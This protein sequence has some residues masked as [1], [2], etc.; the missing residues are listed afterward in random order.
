MISFLFVFMVATGR[1][2]QSSFQVL[3]EGRNKDISFLKAQAEYNVSKDITYC[4]G[5]FVPS[6]VDKWK[7]EKKD[8]KTRCSRK[9]KCK[10]VLKNFSRKTLS[11][12]AKR[13]LKKVDK[14][15]SDYDIRFF[16]L[17]K[18]NKT[19]IN[20][21]KKKMIVG[22]GPL[23]AASSSTDKMKETVL[24]Q[25]EE[26]PIWPETLELVPENEQV[27]SVKGKETKVEGLAAETPVVEVD[28]V[29]TDWVAKGK[30]SPDGVPV[31]RDVVSRDEDREDKR[32]PV[33][34]SRFKSFAL[35]AMKV[36]NDTG[37]FTTFNG[38]WGP[39]FQF[40]SHYILR[41]E[42]GMHFNRVASE[43]RDITFMVISLQMHLTYLF[44]S[45]LFLEAGG[46]R[47][48]WRNDERNDFY[49]FTVGA[50]YRF[51]THILRAVDRIFV[52]MGLV[53]SDDNI[54][55]MKAGVGLSF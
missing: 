26:P 32:I 2:E 19:K 49:M 3:F 33:S 44:E 53:G 37:D 27:Q 42:A 46:G 15:K 24:E 41:G 48:F 47:Q 52:S 40:N 51:R 12:I 13:K 10:R 9:Y 8:K 16:S 7:C 5:Y 18:K 4:R 28:N 43:I 20:Q 35:T 39:Y 36:S 38:S 25:Q 55:E 50:G 11:I 34:H 23:L 1:S 17:E 14:I 54:F 6:A 22:K 29:E 30:I 31:Y 45:R 21:K